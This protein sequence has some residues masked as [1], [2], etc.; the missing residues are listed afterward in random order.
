[1]V[2]GVSRFPGEQLQS[3]R[4]HGAAQVERRR[5]AVRRLFGVNQR[6]FLRIIEEKHVLLT[7][8]ASPERVTC[9]FD[10]LIEYGCSTILLCIIYC[11]TRIPFRSFLNF[12]SRNGVCAESTPVA[13]RTY[14]GAN[15]HR[16]HRT[17]SHPKKQSQIRPISLESAHAAAASPNERYE[18]ETCS[19]R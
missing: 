8:P 19:L 4:V 5:L 2:C 11:S 13:D 18:G 12:E 3:L 17:G 6:C 1:L 10:R 9:K 15:G 14:I 16:S 7:P